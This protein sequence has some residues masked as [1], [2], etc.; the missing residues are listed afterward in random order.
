MMTPALLFL[1]IPVI[2]LAAILLP[3]AL[4]LGV[5]VSVNEASRPRPVVEPRAE[6]PAPPALPRQ[7]A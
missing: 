1:W 4:L 7:A 2:A 3:G 5:A 6:R